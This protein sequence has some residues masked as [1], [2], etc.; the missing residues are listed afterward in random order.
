MHSDYPNIYYTVFDEENNTAHSYQ[1]IEYIQNTSNAYINTEI[2]VTN[3]T[4]IEAVLKVNS[5]V[6]QNVVFGNRNDSVVMLALYINGNKY[7]AFAMRDMSDSTDWVSTGVFSYDKLLFILDS[8]LQKGT[9]ENNRGL[10]IYN[11]DGTLYKYQAPKYALNSATGV[12]PIY[13]FTANPAET[14]WPCKMTLYSFKIINTSG[15]TIVRDY[16]PVKELSTNK[17]GLFDRVG[18]KFYTSP[19]GVLFTGGQP[20]MQDV[21]NVLYRQV[22]YISNPNSGYIN[23]GLYANSNTKVECSVKFSE[24]GRSQAIFG[25]RTKDSSTQN[26][27]VVFGLDSNY[28]RNDFISTTNQISTITINTTT[29]YDII[30]QGGTLTVNGTSSAT[31]SG[32]LTNNS[33]QLCL[34]AVNQPTINTNQIFTGTM[35]SCKIYNGTTL[36]RDYVPAIRISD[37]I[38]G[39]FDR[40]N[41]I[42][43]TATNSVEFT[44]G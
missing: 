27:Y 3:R 5:R 4:R 2:P 25:A 31:I 29:T 15:N 11:M 20:V 41:R 30:K 24:V 38:Y 42:F 6:S 36:L 32:T 7:F 14:S 10:T 23:T 9:T 40:L 8:S 21:N 22:S 37:N 12:Q 44:G 1:Q 18:Q 39:L 13:I 16:V 33:K 35:Y 28:F 34:F 43:Y 17:Y 26:S 19:N